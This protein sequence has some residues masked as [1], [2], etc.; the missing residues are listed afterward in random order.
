VH[1]LTVILVL[2][3]DLD[4]CPVAEGDKHHKAKND[5]LSKST[6]FSPLATVGQG[7]LRSMMY[8]IADLT[9]ILGFTTNQL[10]DRLGLLSPIF[11]EDC[12]RGKK[13]R[14]IVGDKILAALRRMEELEKQ[15]L[16]PKDAKGYILQELGNTD[17]GKQTSF[18]EGRQTT[19]QRLAVELLQKENEHLK[20]EI[21]WLRQRVEELTPLALP[22]PRR[23]LRKLIPFTAK[24]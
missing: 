12:Q 9:S 13:G 1:E 11:A 15:G 24:G 21:A 10:R 22:K 8:T 6:H 16:S 20:Q 18:T 2:Y 3:T 14:I 23:W 4:T 7:R 19:S 17:R 5:C